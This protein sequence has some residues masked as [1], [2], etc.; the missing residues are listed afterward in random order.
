[1]QPEGNWLLQQDVLPG[2]EGISLKPGPTGGVVDPPQEGAPPV[3]TPIGI[4]VIFGNTP[5]GGAADPPPNM[6]RST[7][8]RVQRYG[9][10]E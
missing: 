7:L 2:S 10:A 4:G 9:V 8:D 3:N 1:M 6:A 5:R